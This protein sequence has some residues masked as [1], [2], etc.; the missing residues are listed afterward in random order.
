MYRNIERLGPGELVEIS[1]A[2]ARRIRFHDFTTKADDQ[3]AGSLYGVLHE[4]LPA[5]VR[6]R[7]GDLDETGVLLSGGV[8]SQLMLALITTEFGKAPK[9]FTFEYEGYEGPINEGDRAR[10]SADHFG[11]EHTLLRVS[12]QGLIDR[13]PGLL[14]ST[15]EPLA[16]T[17]HTVLVDG[18]HDHDVTTLITGV[19][20]DSLYL[21]GGDRKA[22]A[23]AALPG[24]LRTAVAGGAGSLMRTG[25]IAGIPYGSS[26]NRAA[27]TFIN[28]FARAAGRAQAGLN[29]SLEAE[30]LPLSLREDTYRDPD[31]A[32]D[33]EMAFLDLVS[34]ERT[35]LDD[36]D[37][38]DQLRVL[39]LRF[40]SADDLLRRDLDIAQ[41]NG[42][43]FRSPFFSLG[44]M[45]RWMQHSVPTSAS[46]RRTNKEWTKAD[47][48][49]FATTVLPTDMAYAPKRGHS[50]PVH[51]WLRGPLL[52]WLK[53]VTTTEELRKYGVFDPA[54]VHRMIDLHA[55]GQG[56]FGWALWTI[57]CLGLWFDQLDRAQPAWVDD[58]TR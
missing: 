30:F 41:A 16:R 51:L 23:I 7:V 53:E 44:L 27:P 57:A 43:T 8:D 38:S 17:I 35:L 12:P 13:L 42:L 32:V 6:D 9:T 52:P 37:P 2:S 49:K 29:V 28:G 55:S 25:R 50:V 47:I 18:V 21:N 20:A 15:A 4:Q 34:T 22:L 26:K 24:P 54:A 58:E 48:R 19:G 40:D 10:A 31:R 1:G 3:D 39:E 46:L 45:T 56:Q 36:L 14:D 11:S 33:G 5:S